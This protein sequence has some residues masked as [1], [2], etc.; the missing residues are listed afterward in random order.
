MAATCP[1]CGGPLIT[2][3]PGCTN[4]RET[5]TIVQ[6]PRQG[7]GQWLIYSRITPFVDQAGHRGAH[8]EQE[9]G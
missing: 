7:H 3:N 2:I 9:A 5:K 4:G 6:C 1:V 8:T